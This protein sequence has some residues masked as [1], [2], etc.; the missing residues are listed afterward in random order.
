MADPVSVA[1]R[2][3]EQRGVG[4]RVPVEDPAQLSDGVP[5][6]A[7]ADLGEGDVDD[8]QIKG[9]QERGAAQDQQQD[10]TPWPNELTL[11]GH[12]QH[13]GTWLWNTQARRG[14]LATWR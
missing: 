1:T 10:R 13:Y 2:R 12:S 4:D 11:A 9:S 3:D 6:E 14:S 5:A 7:D 8:K